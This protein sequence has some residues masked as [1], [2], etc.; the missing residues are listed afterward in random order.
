MP[1]A[2][3]I[4]RKTRIKSSEWN[5]NEKQREEYHLELYG[6]LSTGAG[7]GSSPRAEYLL[8]VAGRGRGA[9]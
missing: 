5:E 6:E 7:L 8:L 2:V 1:A 9:G 3:Q 4:N